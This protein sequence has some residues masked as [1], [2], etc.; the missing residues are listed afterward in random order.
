VGGETPHL[1]LWVLRSGFGV[2]FFSVAN[3]DV[4][5]KWL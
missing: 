4:V 2:V 1:F 3:E 5:T